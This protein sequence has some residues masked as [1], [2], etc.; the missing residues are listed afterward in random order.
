MKVKTG[1]K[2]GR[3]WWLSPDGVIITMG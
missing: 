2:G 3:E 1:I